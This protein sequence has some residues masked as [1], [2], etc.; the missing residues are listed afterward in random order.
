AAVLL[1]C[2]LGVF[3]WMVVRHAFEEDNAVLADKISALT[4]DLKAGGLPALDVELKNV[5]AGEHATYWTRVLDSGG[6]TLT[7]TPEMDRLLPP[8]V[9]P[10]PQDSVSP[11]RDPKSY[12]IGSQVFSLVSTTAQGNN[13]HYLIQVAQDRSADEQF[14]KE[15]GLLAAV[16]VGLGI[17][18]SAVMAVAV[19]RRSLR[20]LA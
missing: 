18:A 5:R 10:P 4:V 7:E 13:G 15:F 19:T 9:F 6:T 8:D 11:I 2:G 17:L 12:R 20:P 14:K 16:V 3:Y 1:S